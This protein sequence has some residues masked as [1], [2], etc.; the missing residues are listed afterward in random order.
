MQRSWLGARREQVRRKSRQRQL[1]LEIVGKSRTHPTAQ[2]VFEQARRRL[3]AISL[4]TVYRNLR[5]LAK[6]GLLRENKIG[7]RSAHFEAPRERH[8]H[9]WCTACGR[10]EDLALSYQDSLDRKVGRLVPYRL[11]EHRLEFYG[12]CPRCVDRRAGAGEMARRGT[13]KGSRPGRARR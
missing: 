5:L 6:E 13:R 7:N 2:E 8:Y 9:I 10:L 1:V 3:P 11:R 4:G 12:L